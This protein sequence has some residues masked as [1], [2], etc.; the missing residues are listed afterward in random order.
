MKIVINAPRH[1]GEFFLTDKQIQLM[2]K[3]GSTK[4]QLYLASETMFPSWLYADL[5]RHDKILVR[6]VEETVDDKRST[7]EIREIKGDCYYIEEYNGMEC[8]MTPE[9]IAKR[10]VI[11]QE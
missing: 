10:W 5:D 4:A 2:A 9:D 6:V 7:L 3:Y 1:Y 8:I 11:V